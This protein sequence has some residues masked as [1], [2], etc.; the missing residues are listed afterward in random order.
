[1]ANNDLNKLISTIEQDAAN[2]RDWWS[3]TPDAVKEA[4]LDKML[5]RLKSVTE[6]QDSEWIIYRLAYLKFSE[7]TEADIRQR[8]GG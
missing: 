1:M 2:A 7:L 3:T 4:L 6:V 5:S 8:S